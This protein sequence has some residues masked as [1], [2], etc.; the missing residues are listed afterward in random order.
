MYT[1][2]INNYNQIMFDKTILDGI[3]FQ[4]LSSCKF[5]DIC[6]GRSGAIL[7][8]DENNIPIV[9]TTTIYK[10]APQIF[11]SIHYNIINKIQKIVCGFASNNI[12]VELY[13]NKYTKMKYHSDQALDLVDNSFICLLSC[14]SNPS[15]NLRKLKI[16]NKHTKTR[17]DIQLD[18]NSIVIFDTKTNKEY[19]HSIEL[20]KDINNKN[21]TSNIWLGLT[22]RLSKTY[23]Y[24]NNELPYFVSNDK[25][26]RLA[27]EVETKQFYKYK[28]LENTTLF[29]YPEI[30]YSISISDLLNPISI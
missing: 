24:F 6:I 18:N 13:D 29:S 21:D 30:S 19:I 26:L 5:E 7:V 9:R 12:L 25:E 10:T 17:S 27:N 23:I 16:M 4:M 2:F 15:A 1:R 28:G 20:S 22:F 11:Q 14:Y 8:N 3:N